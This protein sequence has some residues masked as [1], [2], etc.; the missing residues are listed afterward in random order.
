M[1]IKIPVI[2]PPATSN[3]VCYNKM[4]DQ[5]TE[6]LIIQGSDL[7]LELRN[8]SNSVSILQAEAVRCPILTKVITVIVAQ[9]PKLKLSR[10]LWGSEV[11]IC[12][13]FSISYPEEIGFFQPP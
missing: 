7:G 10:T 13:V 4:A 9:F 2:P 5:G 3:W 11:Q 8:A 1:S 6:I 12:S